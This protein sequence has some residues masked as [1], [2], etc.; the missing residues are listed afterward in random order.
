MKRGHYCKCPLCEFT[1]LILSSFVGSWYLCERSRSAF[2]SGFV[3][4][5]CFTSTGYKLELHSV[6]W[7]SGYTTRALCRWGILLQ[8]KRE[9]HCRTPL[10]QDCLSLLTTSPEILF[11]TT[12]IVL[13]AFY[14]V[15]PMTLCSLYLTV[16]L[17]FIT[18]HSILLPLVYLCM[19][20]ELFS[21]VLAR[22]ISGHSLLLPLM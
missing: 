6:W 7:L 20:G 22:R 12:R 1:S 11:R 5:F 2:P 3:V 8:E 13:S 4:N 14:W 15:L 21:T 18:H 19:W 10:P 17:L 16:P 9:D